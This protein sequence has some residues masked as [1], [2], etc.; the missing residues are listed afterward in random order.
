MKKFYNKQNGISILG[1]LILGFI[2]LL[3]LSYFNISVKGVVES[4]TGQENINY[5]GGSA[6][7]LWSK[8]LEEPVTNFYKNIWIPIF[9]EPFLSNMQR[10]G[11]GQ[12]SDIQNAADHLQI[13]QQ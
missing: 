5:V 9:W 4:P 2:I 11:N 12:P 1:I 13:P 7:S 6:Q 10:L 8:Y 3:V